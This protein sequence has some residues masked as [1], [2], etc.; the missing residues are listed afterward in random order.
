MLQFASKQSFA[1]KSVFRIRIQEGKID[2]KIAL[3]IQPKI[4]NLDPE[5][6]NPDSKHCLNR[7]EIQHS[8]FSRFFCAFPPL[9]GHCPTI[10]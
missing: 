9:S 7:M 4:P 6:I 10:S 3:G 2:P 8:A 5:S 1:L